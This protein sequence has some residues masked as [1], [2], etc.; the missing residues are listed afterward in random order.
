MP[1]TRA[2]AERSLVDRLGTIL[3]AAGLSTSIEGNNNDLNDALMSALLELSLTPSDVSKIQNS[4]L[5]SIDTADYSAFFDLAELR[6]CESVLGHL[7]DVDI[8]VGP[9]KEALGQ[10][11]KQVER[12][13]SRL[14]KYIEAT[15]GLG[16][17]TFEIGNL[18]LNFAQKGDDEDRERASQNGIFQ[19]GSTGKPGEGGG[20]FRG[21]NRPPLFRDDRGV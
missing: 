16:A 9:R 4:D 18:D 8:T 5:S 17:G 19:R 14:K 21:M 6:M 13:V 1:I 10:L 20:G 11:A 12:K 2:Q 7:D 3:T 15:Y